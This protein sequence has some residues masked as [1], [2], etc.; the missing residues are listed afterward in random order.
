MKMIQSR[1]W[2]ALFASS[3]TIIHLYKIVSVCS[4]VEIL[5]LIQ[6]VNCLEG[7]IL[8]LSENCL[9]NDFLYGQKKSMF[10]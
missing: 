1:S 6:N 2:F 4:Y 9:I 5:S 8:T 3:T 7:Y 10:L